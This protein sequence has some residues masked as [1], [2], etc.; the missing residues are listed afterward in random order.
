[1]ITL[2]IEPTDFSYMDEPERSWIEELQAKMLE[3]LPTKEWDDSDLLWLA[4]STALG[5]DDQRYCRIYL[6]ENCNRLY[7]GDYST[8]QTE[9]RDYCGAECELL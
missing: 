9:G 2:I 5:N 7:H 8:N 1:M 4:A 6:C 3:L